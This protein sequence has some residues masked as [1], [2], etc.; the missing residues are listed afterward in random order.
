LGPLIIPSPKSLLR[1]PLAVSSLSDFTDRGFQEVID[2]PEISDNDAK[3]IKKVAFC[4]GKIYYDLVTE[5]NALKRNDVALIRVEQLYPWPAH[6]VAEVLK[7]YPDSAEVIWIQEE[8]KNMGSW[9]YLTGT[10]TLF[11]NRRPRYIGRQIAAAPAV[12]SPKIHVKEQRAFLDELF[13]G[14]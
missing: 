3:L 8:P 14:R 11:G 6:R 2:D 4:T 1:N 9:Y 5:R 10:E 12:G 7:K 13:L